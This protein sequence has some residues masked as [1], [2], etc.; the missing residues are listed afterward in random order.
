MIRYLLILTSIRGG[1][2]I[3]ARHLIAALGSATAVLQAEASV[4]AEAGAVG[5]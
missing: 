5:K 3:R 2:S 1:G 4:L